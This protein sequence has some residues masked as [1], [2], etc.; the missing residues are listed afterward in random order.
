MIFDNDENF[1]NFSDLDDSLY[2]IENSSFKMFVK[3]IIGKNLM[4]NNN[5][6]TF[7]ITELKAWREQARIYLRNETDKPYIIWGKVSFT[8]SKPATPND[9]VSLTYWFIVNDILINF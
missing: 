6:A 5:F 2:T 4:K 1:N 3:E 9:S 7:K 8:A